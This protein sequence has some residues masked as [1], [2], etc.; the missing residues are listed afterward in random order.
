VPVARGALCGREEEVRE[1][2]LTARGHRPG[3]F[4]PA[5]SLLGVK[6]PLCVRPGASFLF[7]SES[8]SQRG[9]NGMES[10]EKAFTTRSR[11]LLTARSRERSTSWPRPLKNAAFFF[12]PAPYQRSATSPNALSPRGHGT[13]RAT[14]FDAGSQHPASDPPRAHANRKS[15]VEQA[16]AGRSQSR[17]LTTGSLRPFLPSPLGRV[18]GPFLPRRDPE[19]ALGRLERGQA[20]LCVPYPVTVPLRATTAKKPRH[21]PFVRSDAAFTAC[22]RISPGGYNGSPVCRLDQL[23]STEVLST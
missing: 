3:G 20:V 19:M 16:L 1:W 17:P 12:S 5:S 21:R 10:D 7:G 15:L 6:S 2:A 13:I 9:K 8:A 23:M 11:G 14:N 22:V 18:L 4:G